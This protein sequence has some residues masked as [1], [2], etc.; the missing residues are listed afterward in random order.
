MYKADFNELTHWGILGMKWGVRRYQNEDGTLTEA[1]KRRYANEVTRNNMKKKKD[2]AEESSLVDAHRWAIEDDERAKRVTDTASSIVRDF[3]K[4]ERDSRPAPK[5]KRLDL[6]DMTEKDLRDKIN[7]EL[8]ER[9]SNSLFA[10]QEK[11]KLSK[12]REIVKQT[13]EIGGSAL[14][15]ASSGLALALTIRQLKN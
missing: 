1:G 4:I 10:P 8:L 3:Q 6:S 12:G 11:P 7:R 9:Q 5:Q 13:L 2:R 14:G 15:I